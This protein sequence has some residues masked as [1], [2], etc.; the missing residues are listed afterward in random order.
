MANFSIHS[1]EY[2]ILVEAKRAKERELDSKDLL[3]CLLCKRGC[4]SHQQHALHEMRER[5]I[6]LSHLVGVQFRLFSTTS[7]LSKIKIDEKIDFCLRNS[8]KCLAIL[9]FL[10]VLCLCVCVCVLVFL[11]YF[12]WAKRKIFFFN[13]CFHFCVIYLMLRIFY[14]R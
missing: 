2:H 11:S 8:V 5:F 3:S 13:H 14:T 6:S 1:K 10:C 4:R 7:R 9:R 12:C